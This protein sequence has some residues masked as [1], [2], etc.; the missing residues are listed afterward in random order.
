MDMIFLPLAD[1]TGVVQLTLRGSEWQQFLTEL[2][3][4][5]V[6]KVTGVVHARPAKDQNKVCVCLSLFISLCLCGSPALIYNW[7]F[8]KTYSNT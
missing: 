1:A 2:S 8:Y 4:E 3:K 6:V 7:T 5:S